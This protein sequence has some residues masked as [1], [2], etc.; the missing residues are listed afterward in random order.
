MRHLHTDSNIWDTTGIVKMYKQLKKG[1]GLGNI[2]PYVPV[3]NREPTVSYWGRKAVKS[4]PKKYNILKTKDN[5]YVIIVS[6]LMR[7]WISALLFIRSLMTGQPFKLT[8]IISPIT[9]KPSSG[10]AAKATINSYSRFFKEEVN[11]NEHV[12]FKFCD[13]IDGKRYT[14]S[15]KNVTE[16]PSS[17]TDISLKDMYSILDGNHSFYRPFSDGGM[18]IDQTILMISNSCKDLLKNMTKIL[19]YSHG[20]VLRGYLESLQFNKDKIMKLKMVN[21]YAIVISL[22]KK[23]LRLHIKMPKGTIITFLK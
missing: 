12:V 14:C 18:R 2:I 11:K 9:E 6:P 13:N 5:E 16:E 1:G 17:N 7:T 4:L 22:H 3:F 10:Y 19:V 8:L 20:G 15:L 21:G 23:R